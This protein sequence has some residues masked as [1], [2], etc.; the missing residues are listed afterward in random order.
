MKVEATN[1]TFLHDSDSLYPGLFSGSCAVICDIYY[2]DL[3]GV[4]K[5]RVHHSRSYFQMS[6]SNLNA[7]NK[8]VTKF[9]HFPAQFLLQTAAAMSKLS[10]WISRHPNSDG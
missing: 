7:M 1:T 6:D 5:K 8:K 10:F 9:A 4:F 3:L 2:N